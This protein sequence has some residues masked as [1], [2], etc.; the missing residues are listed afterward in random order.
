M[1]ADLG[2][3]SGRAEGDYYRIELAYAGADTRIALR[4]DDAL[5]DIELADIV[6]LTVDFFAAR[7]DFSCNVDQFLSTFRDCTGY[8][9]FV[10]GAANARE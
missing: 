2:P 6:L 8:V 4:E 1:L 5:S 7:E 9:I 10:K 3:T